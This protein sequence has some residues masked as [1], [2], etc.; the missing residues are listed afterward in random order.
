MFL[1]SIKKQI[2][3]AL[4]L[5]LCLFKI[6]KSLAQDSTQLTLKDKLEFGMALGADFKGNDLLFSC[7]PYTAYSVHKYVE[8][9]IGPSL[10]VQTN[11]LL[12]YPSFM[13]GVAAFGRVHISQHFYGQLENSLIN[14]AFPSVLG[15]VNPRRWIDELFIGGGYRKDMSFGYAHF[16]GFY[17]LNYQVSRSPYTRPILIRAGVGIK[18]N[19]ELLRKE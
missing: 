12:N 3:L 14:R 4:I 2:G 8:L 11:A 9:G 13:Y 7:L 18:L 10:L 17:I 6:E 1:K 19:S 15:N 5:V 16:Q